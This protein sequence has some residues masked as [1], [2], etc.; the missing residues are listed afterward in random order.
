M[1]YFASFF[2]VIHKLENDKGYLQDEHRRIIANLNEEQD[3]AIAE[4]SE[5]YKGKLI[6]EYQKYD[7]LE[8]MYDAL[9]KS[10]DKKMEDLE[11]STQEELKK[12][13]TNFDKQL[14]TNEAEVR[15]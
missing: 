2:Q 13:Q 14:A 8:D 15:R 1:R 12:M 9:R 11:K 7:N 10:Y 4:V 5:Q 6:V 3:R